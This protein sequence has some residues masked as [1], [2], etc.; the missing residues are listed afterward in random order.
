MQIPLRD[1]RRHFA[2]LI[3]CTMICGM[4]FCSSPATIWSAESKSPDGYW[5]GTAHTKEWAGPGTAAVETYVYLRPT[6]SSQPPQL[7][8]QFDDATMWPKGITN[9]D[10]KW[11]DSTHLEIG[12]RGRATIAFQVVKIAELDITIRDLSAPASQSLR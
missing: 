8:A 12:Y 5:V 11:V 1:V 9:V 7:I 10:L 4:A 6:Q 2:Q 3:A